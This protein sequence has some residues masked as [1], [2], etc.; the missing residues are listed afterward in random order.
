MI[1]K[2]QFLRHTSH[3]SKGQKP[4]LSVVPEPSRAD[5]RLFLAY[6]QFHQTAPIQAK[7]GSVLAPLEKGHFRKQTQSTR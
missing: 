4:Q 2:I 6:R 5:H 7:Q 1:F 3:I